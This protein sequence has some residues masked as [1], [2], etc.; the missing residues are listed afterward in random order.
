MVKSICI[1]NVESLAIEYTVNKTK[2]VLHAVYRPSSGN[3]IARFRDHMSMIL[4]TLARADN[5]LLAGNL[6]LD[7][8]LPET[9]SKTP[10]EVGRYVRTVTVEHTLTKVLLELG[11]IYL[12]IIMIN[13]SSLIVPVNKLTL[14]FPPGKTNTFEKVVS[15]AD[16]LHHEGHVRTPCCYVRDCVVSTFFKL[17]LHIT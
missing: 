7:S 4:D 2:W 14:Q 1:Y 9:S 16:M 6:N 5:T 8:F 12:A 11:C 13:Y 3:A 17:C 10:G 15:C